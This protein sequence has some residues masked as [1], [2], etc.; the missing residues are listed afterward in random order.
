MSENLQDSAE[1]PQIPQEKVSA[2]DG[3]KHVKKVRV[4]RKI[5]VDE[6]NVSRPQVQQPAIALSGSMGAPRLKRRPSSQKSEKVHRKEAQVLN[7]PAEEQR[8]ACAI[9]ESTLNI[10]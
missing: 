1:N 2:Q 5:A 4:K 6:E 9:M 3:R 7:F 8:Q 10:M